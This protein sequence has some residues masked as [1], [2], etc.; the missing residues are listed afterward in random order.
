M[1]L[2]QHLAQRVH[3]PRRVAL[4]RAL[5][6]AELGGGLGHRQVE[7]CGAA[8]RPCAASAAAAGGRRPAPSAPRT[9]A[10]PAPPRR[11]RRAPVRSRRHG[12]RD[13]SMFARTR[14]RRAYASAAFGSRSRGHATYSLTNAVCSRSSAR[15]QSPVRR[16]GH[17]AQVGLPR[18]H[19]VG[20]GG[21]PRGALTGPLPAR[22]T[23]AAAHDQERSRS[24]PPSGVRHRD[25]LDPPYAVADQ[26]VR[27]SCRPVPGAGRRR[28]VAALSAKFFSS[29]GWRCSRICDALAGHQRP[30]VGERHVVVLV[31]ATAPGP[32]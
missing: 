10:R 3:P 5:G 24:G 11:A 22:R 8:P 31:A 4:D 6:D 23:R 9:T 12:R 30:V 14:M 13:S 7:P 20:E 29:I 26:H 21:V 15:C 19:E 25:D 18:R 32:C 1:P 17:P 27:T 16:V 28:S 2:G